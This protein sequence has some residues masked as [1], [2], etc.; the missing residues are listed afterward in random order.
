MSLKAIIYRYME[1]LLLFLKI[2]SHTAPLLYSYYV[3][4]YINP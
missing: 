4:L 1:E 3:I 2:H